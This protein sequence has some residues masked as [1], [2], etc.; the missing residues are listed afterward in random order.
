MGSV[1]HGAEHLRRDA[2]AHGEAHENVG[3]LQGL[4]QGAAVG[5]GGKARLVGIHV[6]GAPFVDHAL[7]VA[8]QDV[9][10]PHAQA[11]VVLRAGDA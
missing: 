6:V 3:V 5:L 10:P 8:E 1:R 4:R 2:L 9:F 7:G 11:H